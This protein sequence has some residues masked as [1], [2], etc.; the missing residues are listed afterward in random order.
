MLH[1]QYEKLREVQEALERDPV[2]IGTIRKHAISNGGLVS[3]ELRKKAWP[4]MLGVS[5][6]DISPEGGKG[7]NPPP[8]PPP[9][10]PIH[11]LFV[12]PCVCVC[13][14]VCFF[15]VRVYVRVCGYVR[16]LCM[17]VCMHVLCACGHCVCTCLCVRVTDAALSAHKD[18][19]QVQLDVNRC[20]RRLPRGK[21]LSKTFEGS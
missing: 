14:C 8:P 15:C 1:W 4:K 12:I 21:K 20:H 18:R 10:Y 2:D 11:A 5:V 7:G 9:R 3:N 13:V 16:V 6:C 19:A 17:R